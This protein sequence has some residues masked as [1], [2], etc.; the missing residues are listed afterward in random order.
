MRR[1]QAISGA[2]R[3]LAVAWTLAT[4]L[5]STPAAGSG[6]D[7]N[8]AGTS[9]RIASGGCFSYAAHG[10]R[11]GRPLAV[12]LHGDGGGSVG[13]AYW[14]SLN[15][16]GASHAT[17]AGVLFVVLV[18]P[19]YRT[20]GGSSSGSAKVLDDDYTASNVALVAEAVGALKARYKPTR[21]VV[22]GISGGAATAALLMGR[23]PG[24]ADAALLAACPC[25]LQPWRE[26][27]RVSANRTGAWTASLSPDAELGGVARGVPIR[28]VVGDKDENTLPRFSESYTAFARQRGLDVAMTVV[29][30]ATHSS[31]WRTPAFVAALKELARP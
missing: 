15:R 31:V 23:H 16:E 26:W 4:G 13:E 27:R 18:R 14:Q 29:P 21:T 22:S 7:S 1:G 3:L 5:A 8:D 24:V 20:P 2:S 9:I 17:A 25:Q 12:F 28:L 6:C 19:G 11:N 10:A 30:G